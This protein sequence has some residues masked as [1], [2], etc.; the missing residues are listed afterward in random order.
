MAKK[1][2]VKPI[3]MKAALIA[4]AVVIVAV[5]LFLVYMFTESSGSEE[6]GDISFD[7]SFGESSL[8]PKPEDVIVKETM[9]DA[10]V[11]DAVIFGKYEQNGNTSDG[12]EALEWIVLEKQDDKLLLISRYC[13]DT[14]PVNTTRADTEFA[15]SSLCAWLNGEFISGTFASEEANALIDNGGIK[16]SLLSA[17]D[18]A[19]YYEYDSWRVA[20]ATEYAKSN[21]AR[22]ENGACWWWLLDKGTTANSYSY[23]HFNGTVQS[24]GFA[25]DYNAVAVR[26]LIWVS[27]D[28]ETETE[29][30]SAPEVSE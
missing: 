25:V 13:I 26:P 22:V 30:L 1:S 17:A 9:A 19:K 18:A 21:G 27:A 7:Q 24:K 3:S 15:S 5:G 16:V 11:G 2:D 4:M 8:E 20:T 12:A 23:V 6:S 29:H 28:A 10:N 14:K